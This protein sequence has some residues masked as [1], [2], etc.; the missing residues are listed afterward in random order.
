MASTQKRKRQ[1]GAA[2]VHCRQLKMRCDSTDM[3]PA[4]CSRCQKAGK[5]CTV[6]PDY[7]RTAMRD[8]LNHLE[9]EIQDIRETFRAPPTSELNPSRTSLEQ[10]DPQSNGTSADSALGEQPNADLPSKEELVLMLSTREFF[11]HAPVLETV[12]I[13]IDDACDIFL[14]YYN[15]YHPLFPLL[16]DIRTVVDESPTCRL[17]FWAMVAITR[18]ELAVVLSGPIRSLAGNE[19]FGNVASSISLIH[20]L[21]I[22]AY[23]PLPYGASTE[24]PSW[25]YCGAAVHKSLALGLHRPAFLVDFVNWTLPDES[26]ISTRQR[27]WVACFIVNQMVSSELGVPSTFKVDHSIN[28]ALREWPERMPM[29]LKPL[30]QMSFISFSFTNILGHFE[31]APDGLLP[32]P[33]HIIQVFDADLDALERREWDEWDPSVLVLWLW[34]KLRLYSFAVAS[35]PSD[36]EHDGAIH[37]GREGY[38]TSRGFS[39]ATRTIEIVCAILDP[40]NPPKQKSQTSPGVMSGGLSPQ[41]RPWTGFER[42]ALVYAVMFLLRVTRFSQFPVQRDVADNTIRK[43][44]VALKADRTSLKHDS[45][46]RACD[47]IEFVCQLPD[48]RIQEQHMEEPDSRGP[49]RPPRPE[50]SPGSR[51]TGRVRSRMSQNLAFDIVRCALA[52]FASEEGQRKYPYASG[53]RQKGQDKGSREKSPGASSHPTTCDND[54]VSLAAMDEAIAADARL[55]PLVFPSGIASSASNPYASNLQ[56]GDIFWTD[57]DLAF[58]DLYSPS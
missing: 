57:W 34:T 35:E 32:E 40:S 14:E 19:L 56:P 28:Q 30:L 50:G 2:C 20:A 11:S 36:P 51:P 4:A 1:K 10:P 15:H 27:T 49:G 24:N 8:R 3:F 53:G 23:W 29:I 16:Q 42:A 45:V 18:R 39:I 5:S 41:N 7:Q 46:S 6:N 21:L 48:P 22:L 43:A 52:R 31:G 38:Y 13:T 58:T 33:D 9:R 54:Y 26:A 17:L 25:L 55:G 44:L 47:I 37:H 12:T